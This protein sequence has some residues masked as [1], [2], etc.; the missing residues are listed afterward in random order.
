MVFVLMSTLV[1]TE[2][3]NQMGRL[4]EQE[5]SW[6][7]GVEQPRKATGSS[8]M[9]TLNLPSLLGTHRPTEMKGGPKLSSKVMKLSR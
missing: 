1:D 2:N 6:E 7:L 9:I 5:T 8:L 3:L 4:A